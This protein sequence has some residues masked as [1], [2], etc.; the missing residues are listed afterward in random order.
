M[1]WMLVQDTALDS[2]LLE[3]LGPTGGARPLT[4]VV[5]GEAEPAQGEPRSPLF[6][7]CSHISRPPVPSLLYIHKVRDVF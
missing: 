7:V 1:T 2:F 6:A 5:Q 3:M 4:P